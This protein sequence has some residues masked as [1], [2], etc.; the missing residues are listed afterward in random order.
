[1][2]EW[3]SHRAITRAASDAKL[4]NDLACIICDSGIA[5]DE[6]DADESWKNIPITMVP[7]LGTFRTL[8]T[9]LALL[10]RLNLRVYLPCRQE[11]LVAARVLASVGIP[12]CVVLDPNMDPK[13]DA[14][15]DLAGVRVAGVGAAR[16]HGAISNVRGSLTPDAT[17]GLMI[18]PVSNSIALPIISNILRTDKS[19]CRTASWRPAEFVAEES[20]SGLESATGPEVVEDRMSAWR[21]L[22][23]RDHFCARCRAWRICRGRFADGKQAPDGCA[24]FFDDLASIVEQQHQKGKSHGVELPWQP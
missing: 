16:A 2:C 1:M 5:L 4:R 18:R 23:L 14:L 17:L 21:E 24:D 22:F 13:W 19:P 15:A 6:I 3:V 10:G 8:S 12:T 9:K 11:S 7:E 20:S